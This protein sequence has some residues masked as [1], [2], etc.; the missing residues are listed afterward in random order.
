MAGAQDSGEG[1]PAEMFTQRERT[2]GFRGHQSPSIRIRSL[3]A[4]TPGTDRGTALLAVRP[5]LALDQ[6]Q[7]V[8][9]ARDAL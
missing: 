6:A 8:A 2:A 1:N 4:N 9:K 5:G 7:R 3:R